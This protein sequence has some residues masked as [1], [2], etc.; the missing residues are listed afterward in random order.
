MTAP[1]SLDLRRRLARGVERGASIRG[2][3]RHFEVSPSAAIKFIERVRRAGSLEPD[4]IGGQRKPAL[5]DHT[6]L[7]RVLVDAHPRI[8][9]AALQTTLCEHGAP[10]V[11]PATL[12][13]TLRRLGL[14]HKK[15]P[16]SLPSRPGRT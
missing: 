7:I 13:T 6:D 4:R 8:T 5:A 3:A 12:W 10:R 1:L 16:S 14:T 15:T 11:A 9:L 2:A